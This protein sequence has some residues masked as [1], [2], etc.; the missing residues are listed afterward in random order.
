ML[1]E[2]LVALAILALGLTA[3]FRAMS[4]GVDAAALADRQRVATIAAQSLLAELGQSRPV[5]DGISEGEF[6]SGQHWRLVIEK[7]PRAIEGQPHPLDGHRVTLSV[8]WRQDRQT[9]SLDFRT[10]LV[11]PG[12]E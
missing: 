7:L 8:T 3:L 2:V 12:N 11:A 5:A 1:T 9:R 6:S 4:P 10:L